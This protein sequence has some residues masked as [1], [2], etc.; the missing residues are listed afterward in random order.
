MSNEQ[1]SVRVPETTLGSIP[2]QE[3]RG[4]ENFF[5][6]IVLERGE[7]VLTAL[8]IASWAAI[9]TGSPFLLSAEASYLLQPSQADQLR[10]LGL[11][12]ISPPVVYLSTYYLLKGSLRLIQQRNRQ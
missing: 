5:K 1:P 3:L 9:C 10:Q 12:L 11:T 2:D 4:R 7:S 6:R 8:K